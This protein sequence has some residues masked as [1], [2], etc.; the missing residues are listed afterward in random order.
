MNRK[1]VTSLVFSG[2]LIACGSIGVA[3]AGEV[4]MVSTSFGKIPMI[5]KGADTSGPLV[6][7]SRSQV[8]SITG[9]LPLNM[10]DL[11]SGTTTTSQAGFVGKVS[12]T[13]PSTGKSVIVSQHFFNFL[14][15]CNSVNNTG[16]WTVAASSGLATETRSFRC[17]NL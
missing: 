3:S 6:I 8:G 14:T 4:D 17:D 2:L 7:H 15:F 5:F 11:N 10:N 16:W 1:T 13:N 9:P 12:F